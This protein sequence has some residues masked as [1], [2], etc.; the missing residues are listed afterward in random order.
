MSK[1]K[2]VSPIFFVGCGACVE[3][4]IEQ[5]LFGFSH[6]P[7]IYTITYYSFFFYRPAFSMFSKIEVIMF[8][9]HLLYDIYYFTDRLGYC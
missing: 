6:P 9:K 5:N 3:I 7:P 4:K 2:F 8:P 1:K